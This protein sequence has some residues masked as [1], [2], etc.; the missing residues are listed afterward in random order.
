MSMG[1]LDAAPIFVAMIMKLRMEW[2]TLSKERG[3]KKIS[4]NIIVDDVLLYGHTSGQNL[5][6]FRT[7]LDFLKH[8]SATLKLK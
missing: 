3:L 7:V 5:A 8:H 2:Y 1:T 6:Y 4:S